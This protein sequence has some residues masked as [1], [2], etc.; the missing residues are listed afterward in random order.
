MTL[1]E[2]W[3]DERRAEPGETGCFG[4]LPCER[5]FIRLGID[6]AEA[7]WITELITSCHDAVVE[8]DREILRDR[9]IR[10][11]MP[12]PDSTNWLM[13]LVE[14]S[15]DAVGRRYPLAVFCVLEPSALRDDIHLLPLWLGDFWSVILDQVLA[16]ECMDEDD[17]A[18]RMESV[19]IDLVEVERAESELEALFER[20]LP[21]SWQVIFGPYMYPELL[22]SWLSAS[23]KERG[24]TRPLVFRGDETVAW[25]NAAQ[26]AA[27][28]WRLLAAGLDEARGWQGVAEV[29]SEESQDLWRAVAFFDRPIDA[30]DLAELLTNEDP[31][32]ICEESRTV[33]ADAIGGETNHLSDVLAIVESWGAT[34]KVP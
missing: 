10:I 5:E 1:I 18:D 26:R 25:L 28:L 4:K 3:P 22:K 33:S 13:L 8:L 20:A 31:A 12:L 15:R 29:W 24:K 34:R 21:S 11:A 14:P 6:S 23:T 9:H 16:P 30:T 17:L 19:E 32:Q 7:L 27:L 2:R